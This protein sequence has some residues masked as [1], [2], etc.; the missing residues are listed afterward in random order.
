MGFYNDPMKKHLL[1]LVVLLSFNMA[2][3]KSKPTEIEIQLPTPIPTPTVAVT[4]LPT[5]APTPSPAETKAELHYLIEDIQGT[6]LVSSGDSNVPESAAEGETVEPGD[7]LITK[8]ASE[9]T[10]ALNN[11]TMVHLAANS[12]IKVADLSPNETNDGF[13]SRIELILG[14]ILSE[15]EKLGESHSS[16]E[17]E[18][19]GV[20]CAV[21]GTAF[22]VQKQGTNVSTSTFHG[23]VE[24]QKDGH[25]QQV[26][27]NEHSTYSLKSSGFL[28]QRR[29]SAIEKKHYQTW[30]Q[31][32]AV[33]QQK[34]ADRLSGKTTVHQPSQKASIVQPRKRQAL[35]RSTTKSR[36]APV[37]HTTQKPRPAKK[38][39]KTKP[40]KTK[41]PN[42]LA[43]QHKASLK[44]APRRVNN[45][46]RPKQPQHRSPQNNQKKKKQKK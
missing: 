12:Q 36:Q 29:L 2:C 33:V 28:K 39:Q 9:A 5:F 3:K 11:N 34:R 46:P 22:E 24:M 31:K 23:T 20:V 18:A 38:P 32:K 21:R 43:P 7:E 27:A 44:P 13:K 30:T 6:V 4:A 15:V 16:F 37:G 10:L 26:N 45:P 14:N 40:I 19:G 17:V 42:H 35:Q 25:V 41:K 8:D 1:I